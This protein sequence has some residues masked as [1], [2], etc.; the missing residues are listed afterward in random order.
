MQFRDNLCLSA[1]GVAEGTNA[2]TFK[3]TNAISYT[4]AGRAYFKA[5][6]SDNLAFSA[7]TA[8][9]ASQV[10]AFFVLIDAAGTVTTEQSAIVTPSPTGD[11]ARA[12]EIP[13]PTDKAV[14]GAIIVQTSSSGAFTP[15]STDLSAA[16]VTDTYVN[17]AGDYGKP[18]TV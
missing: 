5:A 6:N 2:N 11:V 14:V 12:L 9:G 3:L 16:G 7:G 17:F 13:N 1:A 18:I 8:L 15:A 4:I 10:C